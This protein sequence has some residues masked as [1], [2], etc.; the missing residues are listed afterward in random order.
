MGVQ[1]A[2]T[3]M[4]YLLDVSLEISFAKVNPPSGPLCNLV[5]NNVPAMISMWA[6]A[7]HKSVLAGSLRDGALVHRQ[8]IPAVP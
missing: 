7:C 3:A 8:D 2:C 1:D 6:P 4:I 5:E